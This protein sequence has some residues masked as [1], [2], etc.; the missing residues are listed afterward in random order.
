M[1]MQLQSGQIADINCRLYVL[2][3]NLCCRTRMCDAVSKWIPTELNCALPRTLLS[4]AI[5]HQERVR[6]WPS[7]IADQLSGGSIGVLRNLSVS[8]WM[9]AGL[10]RAFTHQALSR[11]VKGCNSYDGAHIA[12]LAPSWCCQG[13]FSLVYKTVLRRSQVVLRITTLFSREQ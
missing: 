7:G 13:I 11:A 5:D 9:P 4:G 10:I 12:M 6:T 8:D 3:G 1:N 2:F